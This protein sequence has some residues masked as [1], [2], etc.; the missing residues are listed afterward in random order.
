ML[1]A[2]DSVSAACRAGSTKAGHDPGACGFLILFWSPQETAMWELGRDEE[3]GERMVHN[4]SR[5][6]G[7]MARYSMSG[8]TIQ[9]VP[10]LPPTTKPPSRVSLSGQRSRKGQAPQASRPWEF[11]GHHTQLRRDRSELVL[12]EAAYDLVGSISTTETREPLHSFPGKI[13]SGCLHLTGVLVG[14]IR[15]LDS[16]ETRANPPKLSLASPKL[17]QS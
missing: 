5:P 7:Q 17:P 4:P 11:R 8:D 1:F 6:K 10:L 2:L 15:G 3:P 14:H 12:G 13:G 16:G 9:Y